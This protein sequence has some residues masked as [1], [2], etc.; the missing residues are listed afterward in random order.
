LHNLVYKWPDTATE[1]YRFQ[2]TDLF[3]IVYFRLSLQ[4]AIPRKRL[5]LLLYKQGM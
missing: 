2:S 3:G 4:A 1:T 5:V